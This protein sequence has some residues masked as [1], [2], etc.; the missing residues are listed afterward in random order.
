MNSTRREVRGTRG[1][2]S[3]QGSTMSDQSRGARAGTPPFVLSEGRLLY[4]GRDPLCAPLPVSREVF[5]GRSRGAP[6]ATLPHL[7]APLYARAA[8]ARF[9]RSAGATSAAAAAA[10]GMTEGDVMRCMRSRGKGRP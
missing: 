5:P 1:R 10:L 8:W 6:R 7:G 9:L 4:I 2:L 3:N